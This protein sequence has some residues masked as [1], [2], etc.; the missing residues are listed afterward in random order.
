MICVRKIDSIKNLR[1]SCSSFRLL[2]ATSSHAVR[3]NISEYT[4]LEKAIDQEVATTFNVQKETVRRSGAATNL[5]IAR[6]ATGTSQHSSATPA[7]KCN[8]RSHSMGRNR[9]SSLVAAADA[10]IPPLR[11]LRESRAINSANLPV[12]IQDVTA[13]HD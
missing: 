2:L 13:S 1:I 8:R 5:R 10:R 12:A 4:A 7:G 11:L 6:S 3:A 9:R